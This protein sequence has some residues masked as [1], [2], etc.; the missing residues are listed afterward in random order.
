MTTTI[1]FFLFLPFASAYV[2]LPL[3]AAFL[4]GYGGFERIASALMQVSIFSL[5]F[6]ALYDGGLFVHCLRAGIRRKVSPLLLR[7][8][9]VTC[10]LLFVV[11]SSL[12]LPTTPL[13]RCGAVTRL[14]NLG[15]ESFR[16]QLLSD[17]LELTANTEEER[18]SLPYEQMPES[19]R[20][21]EGMSAIIQRG[22]N[23]H[24]AIKTSGRPYATGWI[25]FPEQDPHVVNEIKVADG[26]YRH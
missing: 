22:P 16:A 24:V 10:I 18:V 5:V 19:F 1:K 2:T 4:L 21:L 9:V 8:V 3:V 12:V 26:I 14:N 15:G 13:R 11:F 17:A 23:G 6:L 7:F 20:Q 25:L